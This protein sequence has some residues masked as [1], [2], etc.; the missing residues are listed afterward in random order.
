MQPKTDA[1]KDKMNRY[2][3][4]FKPIKERFMEQVFLPTES[5][6]WLWIGATRGNEK[7]NMYGGFCWN[8]RTWIASRAAYVLFIGPIPTNMRVCHV[9]DCRLCVRPE[10]L[11][12]GTARDNTQDMIQKG[13]GPKQDGEN[14]PASKF[15]N[16]QIFDIRAS[17]EKG[18]SLARKYQ[19]T[20]SCISNIKS[21]KRWAH[22]YT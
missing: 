5:G 7:N 3:Q 6:C 16:N 1:V 12:L 14:N 15:T 13:R 21:K 10:H 20:D 2:L 18:A 22:I 4:R 9:C 8:K 11:F 19:V 17:K